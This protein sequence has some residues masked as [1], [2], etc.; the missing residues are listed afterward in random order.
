[1]GDPLPPIKFG[2]SGCA[3]AFQTLRAAAFAGRHADLMA[4]HPGKFKPEI[5]WNTE[6]G[7]D[8][9][10]GEIVKAEAARGALIARVAK[11]LGDYDLL[12]CPA[13]PVAP[14][15]PRPLPRAPSLRLCRPGPYRPWKA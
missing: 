9:T 10:A 5:V 4:A 14:E 8:L 3:R 7:L 1:M 11:F 15:P 6:K 12:L 13:A 2:T